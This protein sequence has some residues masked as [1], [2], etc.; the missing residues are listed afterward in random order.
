[1]VEEM[2]TVPLVGQNMSRGPGVS[3]ECVASFDAFPRLR[4]F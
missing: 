2:E 1:M 4:S 3:A